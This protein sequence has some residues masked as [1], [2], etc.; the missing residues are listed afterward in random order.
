[1]PG[2][3]DERVKTRTYNLSLKDPEVAM[4]RSKKETETIL[5]CERER[6]MVILEKKDTI[7]RNVSCTLELKETVIL[8]IS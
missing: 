3:K 5:S 2:L 6:V 4:K 1:M 8:L 7:F